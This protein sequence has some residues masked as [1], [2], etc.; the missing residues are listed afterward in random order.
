MIILLLI[1]VHSIKVSFAL[2]LIKMATPPCCTSS[3]PTYTT[4]YP[5]C[6]VIVP[7]PFQLVSLVSSTSIPY[8]FISLATCP[9]RVVSATV[10]MHVPA[11]DDPQYLGGFYGGYRPLGFRLALTQES[12]CSPSSNTPS[13]CCLTVNA[14]GFCSSKC[15]YVVQT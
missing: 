12:H 8:S 14:S 3:F 6:S 13:Q 7:V 5:L 11:T 15:F 9:A 10:L 2:A 1:G 4:F